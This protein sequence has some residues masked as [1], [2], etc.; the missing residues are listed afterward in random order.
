MLSQLIGTSRKGASGSQVKRRG[1]KLLAVGAASVLVLVG[2]HAEGQFATSGEETQHAPPSPV[3]GIQLSGAFNMGVPPRNYSLLG[4]QGNPLQPDL[5]KPCTFKLDIWEFIGYEQPLQISLTAQLTRHFKD[6]TPYSVGRATLNAEPWQDESA[7]PNYFFAKLLLPPEAQREMNEG[8]M[9][10]ESHIFRSNGGFLV[11][12][13]LPEHP[14]LVRFNFR[15]DL[16][17]NVTEK[18]KPR[19]LKVEGLFAVRLDRSPTNALRGFT[20]AF[21]QSL[22]ED[23]QTSSYLCAE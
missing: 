15:M 4:F 23:V 3:F 13:I 21:A 10:V 14:D 18:Y 1:R 17:E 11:T 19:M 8:T 12:E 20:G 9:H 2:A 16:I 5:S 6:K 22:G 7:N